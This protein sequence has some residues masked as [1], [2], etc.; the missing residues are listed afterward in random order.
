MEVAVEAVTHVA[1]VAEPVV[2]IQAKAHCRQQDKSDFSRTILDATLEDNGINQ[3]WLS[4]ESTACE[5]Q[6][7]CG[8]DSGRTRAISGLG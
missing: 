5:C 7:Q 4:N 2:T 1:A 3:A 8:C 6:L